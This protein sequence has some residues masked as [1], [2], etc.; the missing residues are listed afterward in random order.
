MA[1][2]RGAGA[3]A[4]ALGLLL[5]GRPPLFA[6]PQE[7]QPRPACPRPT[8]PPT[9]A[10]ASCTC[11]APWAQSPVPHLGGVRGV[12]GEAEPARGGGARGEAE[13][14]WWNP[15]APQ[16]SRRPRNSWG[17]FMDFVFFE[18]GR[19]RTPAWD[20]V[21]SG[22]PAAA[23]I[24]GLMGSATAAFFYGQLILKR[25]GAG[26]VIPWHQDLPYWKIAGSQVG[27]VWVA[28]D[29]M[30][31]EAGVR[32]IPGSHRWPCEARQCVDVSE[33]QAAD[34]VSFA[35]A[36]GDAVCFDAR[37]VHGSPGNPE[38]PGSSHRRV[39]LRFG[40]DDAVYWERA[41]HTPIPVAEVDRAHGLRH[42]EPIACAHFPRVFADAQA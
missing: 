27:T 31:A 24:A 22:S 8:S 30:P 28:L 33:A 18:H 41:G 36:A 25:G 37:V 12:D 2:R 23:L 19:G 34:A 32:Y 15:F 16:A 6:T 17:D 39:A 4:A 21:V 1:P 20:A 13:V 38:G 10:T 40:G 14:M 26:R 29:D 7:P 35:V 3:A 5:A 42:G 11:A 9:G